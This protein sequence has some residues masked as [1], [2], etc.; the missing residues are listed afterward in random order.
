MAFPAF[1]FSGS[2]PALN[3]T[4]LAVYSVACRIANKS[5]S[6]CRFAASASQLSKT[7]GY[8]NERHVREALRGLVTK[9]FIRPYGTR[10]WKEPQAYELCHPE[11]SES[12][13]SS[14]TNFKHWVKLR[15]A[16][17]RNKI[18]YFYFPLAT[19]EKLPTM[20]GSTFS[21]L[22]AIARMA[23]LNG[24]SFQLKAAELR[25]LAGLDQK[26]FKTE[27]EATRENWVQFGFT[28]S[29]NKVVEVF[30]LD[31]ATGKSLDMLEAE[32]EAQEN[33]ERAERF[34]QNRAKNGKHSPV[35]LLAWFLWAAQ[36][37][38]HH[39]AG[40]ELRGTCPNCH[41]QR[42]MKPAFHVNFFKGTH[43][44][45]R[46]FECRYSGKVLDLIV[47]RVGLTAALLKLEMVHIEQPGEM[48]KAAEMFKGYGKAA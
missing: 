11:T 41:N 10:K 18:G 40:E 22:V 19:Y 2:V 35:N 29:G 20:R 21:L 32:I 12:L 42:S 45:F 16:L 14:S 39:A 43:G 38:L 34:R 24:R 8:H 6:N 9:G 26:T 3:R 23:N 27:V 4:E 30:I 44:V 31:P 28:D 1:I 33:A 47:D 5:K 48:A 15:T 46:C 25:D 13:A 37:N 36:M 17:H 7:T